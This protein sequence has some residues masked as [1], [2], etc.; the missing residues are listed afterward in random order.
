MKTANGLE[1]IRMWYDGR[2]AEL[3]EYCEG[4]VRQCAWLGLLTTLRTDGVRAEP[5]ENYVFGIAS[6]LAAARFS[7]KLRQ[8]VNDRSAGAN[9]D[10]TSGT[11]GLAPPVLK[12]WQ[13][14]EQHS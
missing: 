9:D 6:A 8:N 11:G 10:A 12:T 14:N 5:L 4:D 2:R 7:A 3:Q 1:A 13:C